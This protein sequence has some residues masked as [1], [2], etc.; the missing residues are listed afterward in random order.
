M[1]GA[2]QCFFRHGYTASNI[3]LISQY[4][5]FSRVTVHKLFKN[6]DDAFRQLCR[7]IVDE[8]TVAC[9][10]ILANE[11]LDCWEAIED[12]MDIWLK[13]TFEEVS[14]QIVM[15]DLKYYVQEVADD[16]FTEAHELVETMIRQKLSLG[17]DNQTI[18]LN[19]AGINQA[20]LA[21]LIVTCLDGI[22]G[23]IDHGEIQNRSH[24]M[25]NIFRIATQSN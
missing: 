20:D 8:S 14:D 13:P 25:V 11:S 3:T 1:N 6:K 10:P 12:I 16:I 7:L 2:R 24:Q 22:R 4:A 17:I 19:K 21:N 5:G 18:D 15:R 9:E 23:H